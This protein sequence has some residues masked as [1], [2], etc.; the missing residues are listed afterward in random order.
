MSKST[1]IFCQ[2]LYKNSESDTQNCKEARIEKNNVSTN[3]MSILHPKSI[4]IQ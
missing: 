4:E 2:I 3:N 1:N